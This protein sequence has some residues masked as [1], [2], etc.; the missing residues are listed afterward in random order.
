MHK[1][2]F[3]FLL[4]IAVS[5]ISFSQTRKPAVI[6]YYSGNAERVD[7][8]DMT[9][10]THIIFSFGHLKGNRLNIDDARDTL[11]IKKLVEQ[12]KK[13]PSL[14]ILLSLGGWGGCEPCSD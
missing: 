3:F 6:A 5:S 11:T 1:I 13:N 9:K 14:R 4:S 2:I 10:L 7:S 12:K 8:F